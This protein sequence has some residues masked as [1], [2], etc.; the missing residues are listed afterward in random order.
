MSGI[1]STNFRMIAT[2]IDAGA[3]PS[4]LNVIWQAIWIPNMNNAAR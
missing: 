1:N 4:A 3:F 2:M